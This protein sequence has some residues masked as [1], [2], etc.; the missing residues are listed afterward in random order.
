[1]EK[2]AAQRIEAA[3]QNRR[4]FRMPSGLLFGAWT[5]K[6]I[7][8][9]WV[10]TL[11]Q[12]AQQHAPAPHLSACDAWC[13]VYLPDERPPEVIE[14]G[15]SDG[16]IRV[17]GPSG[18]LADLLGRVA[19]QWNRNAVATPLRLVC[20]S[21]PRLR[22]ELTALRGKLVHPNAVECYGEFVRGADVA[23]KRGRPLWVVK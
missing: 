19:D 5:G 17:E 18:E 6:E 8:A 9:S 23:T 3:L 12:N 2:D 22:D 20:G 11:Q 7:A 16:T 10:S 14:Y 15:H 4:G 21:L 13:T 1:M